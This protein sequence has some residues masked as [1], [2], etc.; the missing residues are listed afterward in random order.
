M[1][2]TDLPQTTTVRG[3]AGFKWFPNGSTNRP[4]QVHALNYPPEL[5]P[6]GGLESADRKFRA[7]SRSI[8]GSNLETWTVGGSTGT[9]EI[10]LRVRFDGWPESLLDLVGDAHDGVTIDYYPR[11][12][13]TNLSFPSELLGVEDVARIREDEDRFSHAEYQADLRLKDAS[14]DSQ[15]YWWLKSP[16]KL[17]N[18][19]LARGT[20]DGVAEE[21]SIFVS[22][23][24]R[25]SI[26]TSARAQRI[27]LSNQETDSIRLVQDPVNGAVPGDL[28]K[29]SAEVR[30]TTL[31]ANANAQFVLQARSSTGIVDNWAKAVSQSS[32]F[33][34]VSV[35]SSGL[36]ADVTSLR[37]Q[38]RVIDRT[39]DGNA[40]GTLEMRD[41][42][43]TLQ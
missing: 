6:G 13:S 22:G 14:S 36:P 17:K 35:T 40:T 34:E 12:E 26:N 2:T 1:P 39:T 24:S 33:S 7:Q 19:R 29:F 27:R 42:K 43:L 23:S 15:G 10:T 28:W 30:A 32:S 18:P 38:A 11:L 25:A 31:S 3:S 16:N 4:E 37:P 5:I 20:T 41:A 21:W 9:E 8:D